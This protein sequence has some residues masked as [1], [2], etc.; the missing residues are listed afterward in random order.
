MENILEVRNLKTS[1]FTKKGEVQAVRGVSFD[2]GKNEIVGI[3]GESGSGKSITSKSIM[4]LINHPGKIVD[5]EVIFDNKDLLKLSDKEMRNIRGNDIS[6]VFQDPMTA[7]NPLLRVGKQMSEIIMRHQNIGKTQA[8][9]KCID[10]LKL[11]G[12]PSPEN[13]IDNYPHEFSGGM[14]QRV[15]IAMAM[16]SSPKLLIADEPTTALDVTIQA[17][18][19]RLI[20]NLNKEQSNSTILITHDL[21][22]VYNTCDRVIVMYGGMIM[23]SGS[24][25]EIFENPKHPYTI[26]LLKSIPKGSST[27]K[28]RLV[29]IE[30]TPP[31]L[32]NPPVGC[33]FTQRCDFKKDICSF[34]KAKT[35]YVSDT[36]QV[37]CWLL[38]KEI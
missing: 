26:G 21:G 24:V 33:P 4:R 12:I 18:I 30:G 23:E 15:C 37:N 36:H 2:I 7:L 35:T 10:M 9:Q 27:Q 29:P 3:V 11:V 17:Q 31:N 6:M 38:D 20:K 22:V 19:L 25:D 1:F 16:S 28:E 8:R 34:S 32:L 14:R 5:G 13:R